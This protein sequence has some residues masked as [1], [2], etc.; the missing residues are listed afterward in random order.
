MFPFLLLT[1]IV[2]TVRTPIWFLILKSYLFSLLL[3]F[4]KVI[5]FIDFFL[6]NTFLIYLI[7][8]VFKCIDFFYLYH[9]LPF[10]L[11]K[12]SS[13]IFSCIHKIK[14]LFLLWDFSFSLSKHLVLN[15]PSLAVFQLCFRYLVHY[16]LNDVLRWIEVL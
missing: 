4:Q 13:S 8:F 14:N 7:S 9:F 3:I 2:S 15:I 11:G 6:R 10:S 5:N 16:I 12:F 1:A